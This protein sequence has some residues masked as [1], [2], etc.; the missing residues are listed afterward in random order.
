MGQRERIVEVIRSWVG[1]S[2]TNGAYKEIIDIYNAEKPLAVG[3]TV[4]YTDA[5]C[6][7]CVSA[8]AIT[9]GIPRD[10]FP[11][12]CGCPR[13]IEMW[14]S[15]GSWQENENYTPLPGDVIYY[16]WEDPGLGDNQG[17]ADHVGLVE[18]VANGQITVIE[19]NYSQSVKRR[20]IAVNGRYIRGFALPKYKIDK[21]EEDDEMTV[22]KF[23][24]LYKA[25][26][27]KQHGEEHDDWADEAVQA[28]INTKLFLGDGSGNFEWKE[29]ITRQELALVFYRAGLLKN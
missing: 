16:D 11:R 10:V 26:I 28:A 23:E 15:L 7:T 12:E 2:V 4:K 29:S 9:A 5:W 17:V 6:Q 21:T 19:G 20:V 8:A 24:E 1:K 13:A 18:S 22:E 27:A 25:M 14:K 3:Y